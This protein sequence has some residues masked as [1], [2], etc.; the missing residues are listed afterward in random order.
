MTSKDYMNICKEITKSYLELEKKYAERNEEILELEKKYSEQNEEILELEKKI[1]VLKK[2]KKKYKK[3]LKKGKKLL[4]KLELKPGQSHKEHIHSD[5]LDGRCCYCDVKIDLKKSTIEHL[6]PLSLGGRNVLPNKMIACGKCN[7]KRSN[8]MNT[9][10]FNKLME[11]LIILPK[12]KLNEI[13][14]AIFLGK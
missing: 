9:P 12:K 11:K 10:L 4:N 5:L 14:D 1:K 2:K 8:K 3:M 7:S 6:Q 13:K